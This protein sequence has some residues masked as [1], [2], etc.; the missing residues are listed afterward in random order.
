MRLKYAYTCKLNK[1]LCPEKDKAL[2]LRLNKIDEME[3]YFIKEISEKEIK[4]KEKKKKKKL[5]Q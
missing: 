4:N 1:K 3:D 5:A 2:Q